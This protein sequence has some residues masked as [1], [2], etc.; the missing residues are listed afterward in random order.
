MNKSELFLPRSICLLSRNEQNNYIVYRLRSTSTPIILL[1]E[2]M[3]DI[4][5]CYLF[6][7]NNTIQKDIYNRKMEIENELKINYLNPTNTPIPEFINRILALLFEFESIDGLLLFIQQASLFSLNYERLAIITE[8]ILQQTTKYLDY[9]RY[10][11]SQSQINEVYEDEII[12]ALQRIELFIQYF[13][14]IQ[15]LDMSKTNGMMLFNKL[16]QQISNAI[17]LLHNYKSVLHYI[18]QLY[19]LFETLISHNQPVGE[20]M[21]KIS[22]QFNWNETT[23]FSAFILDSLA[24]YNEDFFLIRLRYL[25]ECYAIR[26]K[27]ESFTFLPFV[28]ELISEKPNVLGVCFYG[29]DNRTNGKI[30]GYIVVLFQLFKKFECFN[31]NY[32]NKSNGI[33][34]WLIEF[35]DSFEK[36]NIISLSQRN[37]MISYIQFILKQT[38]L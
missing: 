23:N 10:S 8:L 24:N 18:K 4:I 17:E 27:V 13:N 16:N 21:Q 33:P 38:T 22:K 28:N 37:E 6:N 36:N 11:F 35:I 32:L 19:Q 29:Y 3:N 9:I 14:I 30:N 31:E 2:Y 15:T 25:I 12:V 1:N 7:E 34:M 26:D 5:P 20:L